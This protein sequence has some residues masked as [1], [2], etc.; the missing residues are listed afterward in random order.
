MDHTPPEHYHLNA[1]FNHVGGNLPIENTDI[2]A[3]VKVLA[4]QH[5]LIAEEFTE[6][7]EKGINVRNL[8]EV[9][10]GL[11]DVLV[12]VD[13][14]Y[15]RLGLEYPRVELWGDFGDFNY[16]DGVYGIDEGLILLKQIISGEVTQE[17]ASRLL[18][19][20]K[21][22]ADSIV[23]GV[24]LLAHHWGVDLAADQR[25]IVASNMS[26]FDTDEDTAIEGITKYAELE[27]KSELVPNT[28]DGVVYHVI[29]CTESTKGKDGKTYSIGKIL[30]SVNFHEPHLEDLVDDHPLRL[31][32]FDTFERDENGSYLRVARKP[33]EA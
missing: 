27:V 11:G 7:V 14:L 22:S 21:V 31:F 17:T 18:H 12:T 24:Y 9:R 6:M 15:Y 28:V 32:A 19:V 33:I 5:D 26:K 8:K 1:T 13:G 10:D 30:K 25:A 23:H 4:R 29:R 20:I 16:T 3:I 2:D